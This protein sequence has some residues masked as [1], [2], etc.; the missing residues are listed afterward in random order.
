[1]IAS[2]SF[3]VSTP[4]SNLSPEKQVEYLAREV[5]QQFDHLLRWILDSSGQSGQVPVFSSDIDMG[6][7]RILNVA[8]PKASL[9]ATN[10]RFVEEK[11][12]EQDDKIQEIQ[13]TIHNDLPPGPGGTSSTIVLRRAIPTVVN[14]AIDIGSFKLTNDAHVF[15]IAITV[16]ESGFSVA[17]AYAI[18][19]NRSINA[20]WQIALPLV[21]TGA[22]SSQDFDLDI[23]QADAASTLSLRIRRT[24]GATAGTATIQIKSRG[25]IEDSFLES[26]ATA[27]VTAPTVFLESAILTIRDGH[28]GI[29]TKTLN[30]PGVGTSLTISGATGDNRASVELNNPGP[31]INSIVG[32]IRVLAAGTTVADVEA[33]ADGAT[34]AG[35]FR[36]RTK[37]TGSAIA[38][39]LKLTSTKN[40]LLGSEGISGLD[41]E[42]V[43]VLPLGI[44]PATSPSD[45]FQMY[46]ADIVAGNTAPHFRTEN[47]AIVK[48]FKGAALTAASAG[49]LSSGGA[50]VLSTADSTILANAITRIGE[51]EARL[52]AHGLL[53]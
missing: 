35:Y 42:V 23:L 20:A 8:D 36:L 39:A 15:D 43:I 49:A 17:K 28:V 31:G 25:V 11:I 13:N 30:Y 2:I 29:R 41:G 34:D 26:S 24:A 19:T 51:L 10:R 5:N 40:M 44:A 50:A 3:H 38:T 46:A 6:N 48:L 37:K 22:G 53:T 27:S 9:D 4:P 52:Q 12:R 47:G 32:E 18:A 21:D 45:A 33:G 16:S 7:H 1:M 14:D